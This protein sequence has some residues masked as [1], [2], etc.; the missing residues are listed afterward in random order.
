MP[1]HFDSARRRDQLRKL[2]KKQEANALLVT[3]ETN[4]TYLTGFTGDSTFLLL[5]PTDAILISDRRYE[6]QLEDECP[7]LTLDIRGP[8]IKMTDATAEVIASAKVTEL[9]IEAGSMTVKLHQK[10]SKAVG[11]TRLHSTT[12]LVEELRQIKDKQEIAEIRRSIRMA[13]RTF[14]AMR[15]ALRADQSE[16]M[17]A[18][19]MEHQI[20]EFGGVGFAFT[21]IVGVGPRAALPH[22]RP[23]DKLVGESTFMLVDWGAQAGLYKSDLTR[24]LATGKIPAK[25]AKIHETVL[26]AQQAAI[27]MIRPGVQQVDVDTAARSTIEKAGFGKR[28]GHGLGHGFGLQIHED[29]RMSTSSEGELK[30]GMVVTVEPGIYFPGWGGVRLEDDVLVTRDGHEV[31]SSLPK[32]LEE[33][34]VDLT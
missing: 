33:C 25:L 14:E 20:R 19:N 6:E 1:T 27:D 9:G 29:P 5:T 15:A 32:R 10:L 12:G 31:L 8:G 11:S 34:V 22:G 30:T 28:F 13:E 16:R 2:L 7:D 23:S 18:A 17:I 3:S 4:V 24:V 21:P 26:A